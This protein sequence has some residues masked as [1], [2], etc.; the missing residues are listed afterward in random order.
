MAGFAIINLIVNISN[1]W[2]CLIFS[3]TENHE[4]QPT[5]DTPNMSTTTRPARNRR[6]SSRELMAEEAANPSPRRAKV[7]P[8]SK[9]QQQVQPP[10][11]LPGKSPRTKTR[12]QSITKALKNVGAGAKKMWRRK[13]VLARSMDSASGSAAPPPPPTAASSVGVRTGNQMAVPSHSGFTGSSLT[14]LD[15]EGIAPQPMRVFL[16]NNSYYEFQVDATTLAGEICLEMRETLQVHNDAACSVFSYSYGNYTVLQ[17]DEIVLD[18]VREWSPED[19]EVGVTRLVYKAR[20]HIPA[21]TDG[22]LL[23]EAAN[24]ESESNGAHRLCYIDA[25]HRTI[26]GLYSIP[27]ASAPTLAA[28]QL[29]SA[30]GDYDANVHGSTYISDSGL[31]N[32]IAP[33]LMSRFNSEEDLE[34]MIRGEHMNVV[35]L[36][37]FDAERRYMDTIKKQVEYYGATFF[38]VRLMVQATD[39]EDERSEPQPAIVAISFD[40]IFILSGWNLAAQDFHSYEVVTKWTVAEN[41]DL[42]AFSVHDKMIYFLLCEDPNAIEDCVQM[43]ISTI[44][45]QRQGAPTPNRRNEKRI[46]AA[47]LERFGSATTAP[48]P[49]LPAATA[50]TPA[51]SHGALPAGWVAL[52]DEE[53]GKTYFWHEDSDKTS[54]VH[55]SF[56]PSPPSMPPSSSKASKSPA[57]T[58]VASKR[59]MNKRRKSALMHRRRASVNMVMAVSNG[60]PETTEDASAEVV[61]EA[62]V[63]EVAEVAEEA[64]EAAEVEEASQEASLEASQEVVEEVVE[65]DEV[66][67]AEEEVVVEVEEE[68][69]EEASESISP[70]VQSFL[71]TTRLEKY[72]EQLQ[73]LGVEA[74]EDLSEILEDDLVSIGMKKLEIRRYLAAVGQLQ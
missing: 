64:A 59:R 62:E 49:T 20:I 48:T 23:Q 28:L 39:S 17:D 24:A 61:E 26:T 47:K 45:S 10:Q 69:V 25:V 5:K 41:P 15:D 55:P 3:Q 73:D 46:H 32:Y 7:P 44:I 31:E 67:V 4:K 52:V 34:D 11:P 14:V 66:E 43:H 63:A 70:S 38:A 27:L 58:T 74:V 65:E 16:M 40:G 29:Q 22:H 1:F 33:A 37:K 71:E 12:R 57:P 6:R 2:R 9:Q 50:T 36:S 19:A 72:F 51:S 21:E 35:G 56:K 13:S 68:E 60:I 42:F 54:W 8:P 18:A 30:I 53:S